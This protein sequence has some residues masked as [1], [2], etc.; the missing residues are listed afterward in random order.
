MAN[1]SS[2]ETD[3]SDGTLGTSAPT[4]AVGSLATPAQRIEGS[5]SCTEAQGRFEENPDLQS[6]V[7]AL[8]DGGFA[9][10]SRQ[11]FRGIVADRSSEFM[12]H[13]SIES[14]LNPAGS[15]V[16]ESDASVAEACRAV[17][18]HMHLGFAEELIVTGPGGVSTIM[19][20]ELLNELIV[21]ADRFEQAL[22]SNR[23]SSSEERFRSLVQNASDVV[24]LVN[25]EGRIEYVSPAVRQ[26]MG[27]A[28]DDELGKGVLDYVHP[29]HFAEV[30]E[31]FVE[32]AS[33]PGRSTRMELRAR[34]HDGSWRWVDATATNLL[35]DQ[36]VGGLV[37]NYRDIT[38]RKALE[39]QLRHQAFHDPLTGLANRALLRDRIDHAL[40]HRRDGTSISAVMLMDIDDFKLL[41]D[42]LGHEAGDAALAAVAGRL[43][44]VLRPAD[45][46]ARL[47]GDEFAIFVEDISSP[48]EAV[49][50]GERVLT[51][52]Q[53]PLRLGNRRLLLR[54]SLGVAL[55]ERGKQASDEL[56][57]NADVAMYRAKSQQRGG[58]ALYESAMHAEVLHRLQVIEDL[59]VALGRGQ[60]FL[61]YQPIVALARDE[62]VEFEALIRWNHP[63]R[64]MVSPID[65]ISAAEDTGLIIEIGE[66]VLREACRQ[67]RAWQ[68]IDHR[69]PLGISV[70]LSP[71][72]F[73][74]SDIVGTVG[75]ALRDSG[76]APTDLTLEITEG[77]LV[78]DTDVSLSKLAA[79]KDLGVRLSIDDF[80]TGYSSL[81]Y[82]HRFPID[83]LKIDKSF[84]DN[85]AQFGDGSTLARA[86]IGLGEVLG[87]G[88]VGEGIETRE[89]VWMLVGLGCELG[90]G[91]YFSRPV[92][93]QEAQDLLRK[94]FQVAANPS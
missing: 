36:A 3:R 61:H 9:P 16:V 88:T 38:D 87:V 71:K 93:A 22:R 31:R 74:R 17:L 64:G 76:L 41:N 84:V 65:F 52:V 23:L 60:L 58:L 11:H 44:E 10:L 86:V 8:S 47:G 43:S 81:S 12:N 70:N 6:V 91:Y 34:H 69:A 75:A 42:S 2:N 45:T 13:N 54:S 82:L 63:T 7:V 55:A 32:V 1:E 48:D 46:A 72:Q 26:V 53:K 66:W 37:I 29:D 40:S 51:A 14:I 35:H 57:R 49:R 67:A 21:S 80:G 89:Q 24:I 25:A 30:G 94:K 20:T 79:L 50:I 33:E 5:C 28:P 15:V 77:L 68:L 92:P 62:I 27:Y 4:V 39:E 59:Q 78:A 18:T 19:L 73:E 85:V 83:Q 90:Q 56:L